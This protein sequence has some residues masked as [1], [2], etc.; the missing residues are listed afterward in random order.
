MDEILVFGR[1]GGD[2]VEIGPFRSENGSRLDGVLASIEAEVVVWQAGEVIGRR[3][4]ANGFE[5]RAI[6]NLRVDLRTLLELGRGQI[7]FGDHDWGSLVELAATDAGAFALQASLP[8]IRRWSEP[9][10][11]IRIAEID[12]LIAAVDRIEEQLGD[13]NGYLGCCGRPDPTFRVT[14]PD[15]NVP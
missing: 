7:V 1:D 9:L 5:A 3:R 10:G 4:S 11:T 12:H 13:L 8:E 14:D 6:V 15:W 2:R